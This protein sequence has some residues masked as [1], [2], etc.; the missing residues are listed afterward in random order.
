[1]HVDLNAFFAT[2]ELLR[3]PEYVGKPLIVAGLGPRGVVS[4]A[5]Y[6][7]RAYGVHSAMPTYQA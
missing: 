5:S 4:T 2:A 1:M 7:A 3:H 6:E